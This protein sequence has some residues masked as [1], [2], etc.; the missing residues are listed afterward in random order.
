M[1]APVSQSEYGERLLATNRA[2]I[3]RVRSTLSDVSATALAQRPPDGGWSIAE[4]LEHLIVSADSYLE[5]LRRIVRE[6][7]RRTASPD[8]RWK[9]TIA[10]G[11]LVWSMRSPRKAPA[12][13]MYKPS[14][15]ARPR[16]LE[17]FL[18]R[19]DEVGRLIVEAATMDWRRVRMRSP[20][21]PII[22]MNI[23]DALTVLVVHAERH[24][25]QIERVKA[26]TSGGATS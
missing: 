23:G 15:T 18:Q 2:V 7:G 4:V 20:V 26:R 3:A 5:Q 1:T 11:L 13:K 19:Q 16:A 24:A 8:A 22:H 21:L 9:P 14:P 25:G 10:G 6:N 12:P 17:E